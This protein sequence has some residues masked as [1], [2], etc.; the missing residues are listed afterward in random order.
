MLPYAKRYNITIIGEPTSILGMELTRD[1]IRKTLELKQTSYIDKIYKK[2]CSCSMTKDFTI[3]VH[4]A[5]IDH[6]HTLTA[7]DDA[8]RSS[9]LSFG[10]PPL[11]LRFVSMLAGCAN[12]CPSRGSSTITRPVLPSLPTSTAPRTPASSTLRHFRPS[13]YTAML[14]GPGGVSRNT[15]TLA[16]RSCSA[17][18]LSLRDRSVSKRI[19][20]MPQSSEE[21]KLYAYLQACKALRFVKQVL[22]CN[23]Y[24]LQLPTR[25]LSDSRGL[26]SF[27][28]RPGATARTRHFA[29]FLLY[30]RNLLLMNE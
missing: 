11:I 4:Q 20:R 2:L 1:R 19:K 8:M 14:P 18:L 21:A 13:K 24:S 28:K 10:Q 5:G 3:P 16:S 9:A 29:K 22:E 25:C 17:V 26:V 6:F 12:S 7:G 23:S 15:M 30:G 27:L